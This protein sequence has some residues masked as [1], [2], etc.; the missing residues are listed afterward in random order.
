MIDITTTSR[1][2][3]RTALALQQPDRVPF[4]WGFC[5]TP[6][7]QR[8]LAAFFADQGL[9][10]DRLRET[11]SDKRSVGPTYVGPDADNLMTGIWGIRT[12][13]AAYDG[14]HYEEFC[15]FPL[16]GIEDPAALRNHAWPDPDWFVTDGLAEQAAT[17]TK[18]VQYFLGNPFELYCWM[19]GME[20]ALMN[21]LVN[22]ALVRAALE[23]ITDFLVERLAR[24]LAAAGAH[25]DIAFFADD[26]GTQNGPLMSPDAYC[27]VLQPFHRAITE[28][29]RAR[30]PGATCMLHSD[31][32]IF[33][34]IPALLHAGVDA[35]EAVQTDAAGMDPAR[36]KR[37]FGD[38]LA[39]HGA[40]SVQQLLPRGT[41]NEVETTCR[42][43][44]DTLGRGGGY[45]AAPS[46]AIQAGTP[47]ENVLA[48]L[49]GVLGPAAVEDVL[50]TA[51]AA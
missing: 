17:G 16:A 30:A 8:T 13:T 45:I 40:I 50:S 47:P 26:L 12:R 4:S 38:R 51:R 44:V 21:V 48:M 33:D 3:V 42:S 7:M 5:A 18:A 36:L 15:D 19:T 11:V 20:E 34:L 29:V 37:T 49:R 23:R 41:P 32:A 46:H 28:T 35:I 24:V 43:L 25:I 27:A 2:R 14:G 22:P 6:E 39:F 1:E 31:G 10:W 9:S